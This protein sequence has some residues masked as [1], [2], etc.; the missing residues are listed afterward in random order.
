MRRLDTSSSRVAS[1][2]LATAAAAA[3]S[4]T[5]IETVIAVVCCSVDF[6]TLE[7]DASSGAAAEGAELIKACQVRGSSSSNSRSSSRS[8]RLKAPHAACSLESDLV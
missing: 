5:G 4:E 7:Q 3:A 8:S 1:S 2:A 6:H